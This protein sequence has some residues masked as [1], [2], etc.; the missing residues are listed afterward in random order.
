MSER[1]WGS[2]VFKGLTRQPKFLGVDYDYS[3]FCAMVSI[4]IFIDFSAWGMVLFP[5]LHFLGW[6]LCRR[7]PHIFRLLMIRAKI[8]KIKNRRIWGLQ[9]YEQN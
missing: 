7:D 5:P 8:G 6:V 3:V 4:L 2:P 9:S 1:L